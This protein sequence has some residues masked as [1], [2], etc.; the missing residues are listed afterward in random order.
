MA[1]FVTRLA[2]RTLGTPPVVRPVIA[3]K[4]APE[5]DG[6]GPDPTPGDEQSPERPDLTPYQRVGQPPPASDALVPDHAAMVQE[7]DANYTPPARRTPEGPRPSVEPAPPE[8]DPDSGPA[9]RGAGSN[10]T[11]RRQR[12]RRLIQTGPLEAGAGFEREDYMDASPL[13]PGSARSPS[14]PRPARSG[15]PRSPRPGAITEGRPQDSPR[16][17]A[18]DRPPPGDGSETL[19]RVEP[20]SARRGAPET[21][22]RPDPGGPPPDPRATEDG[23]GQQD[24]PRSTAHPEDPGPAAAPPT[25]VE[26]ARE[27]AP[28]VLSV[29]KPRTILEWLGQHQERG[30]REASLPEPE[31]SAPAI[32][33]SIGRIEVRASTP[34]PA[35]LPR[36]E[37]AARLAP[38]P[39]LDEYLE[40]RGGGR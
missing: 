4:F 19:R 29:V 9:R 2:E 17:V 15:E 21:A 32:T 31:P 27:G 40:Q 16:P 7:E 30:P 10:V 35:P 23:P 3:P 1:D 22:Q 13:M 33:V 14:G 11:D 6:L 8:R 18:D 37:R 28:T 26:S 34:P 20:T 38:P 24:T 39:S 5:Q 25:N 36:R 12:G